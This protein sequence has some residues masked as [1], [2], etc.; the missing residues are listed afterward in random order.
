MLVVI[1]SY[2]LS[3]GDLEMSDSSAIPV[4]FW[5]IFGFLMV[6]V[7]LLFMVVTIWGSFDASPE[8]IRSAIKEC[9]SVRF[10]VQHVLDSGNSVHRFELSDFLSAC[11][12]QKDLD[13]KIND[14]RNAL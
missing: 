4:V 14:Q 9:P 10:Q 11:T 13:S 8:S 3:Y 1:I 7:I 2:L 5:L 12:A 6:A